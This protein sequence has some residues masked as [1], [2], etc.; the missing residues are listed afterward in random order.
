MADSSELF[1]FLLKQSRVAVCAVET[2]RAAR[3]SAIHRD[4]DRPA[5][6]GRPGRRRDDRRARHAAPPG[7]D[8]RAHPRSRHESLSE[9][10]VG[11]GAELGMHPLTTLNGAEGSRPR[12]GQFGPS[13]PG[14]SSVGIADT[15]NWSSGEASVGSGLGSD[16]PSAR[17]GRALLPVGPTRPR[18]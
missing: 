8:Q 11:A 12:A 17:R 7:S 18:P 15:R 14:S 5:R 16:E 4:V 13:W 2:L 6:L 1:R 9:D 3:P 10:G